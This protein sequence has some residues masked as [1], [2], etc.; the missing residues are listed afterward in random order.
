MEAT[1]QTQQPDYEVVI[2][3]GSYAGLSAAMALGRSLRRVLVIDSGLP[4]NRQTPH[5][6]NFITQ[7]GV[8]PAVI[9]GKAKE[10]VLAYPTVAWKQGL[11]TEARRDGD[12][13]VIGTAAGEQ[14]S[15][16]KLLFAT[17]LNDQLPDLPGFADCWGISVLHCPYCHGY[18]VH[19]KK[20]GIMANGD[21]AFEYVR[22]IHQWSKNIVL[23]T[24]GPSTMT[25][26]YRDKLQ[27]YRIPVIESPVAELQ[28]EGGSIKAVELGDGQAERVDALFHRPAFKQHC[29]LPVE[30]G[31]VLTDHGYLQADDMGKTNVPGVFVVGDAVSM[32]RSVAAAV[33]GGNKAGAWINKE[34]AEAFF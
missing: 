20:L 7:D 9:A 1:L 16:L 31:C 29:P 25:D 13:F 11:A 14:F 3:G 10:Q 28:Q 30:L 17:G 33:A 21:M 34:L 8:V 2:I 18:E 19:G 32:M 22:L 15:A 23:F 6:H 5:S 4:C 26:A 27:Q 12:R 24:N